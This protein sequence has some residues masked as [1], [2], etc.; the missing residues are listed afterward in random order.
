MV[1]MLNLRRR[2]GDIKERLREGAGLSCGGGASVSCQQLSFS[3]PNRL[4]ESDSSPFWKLASIFLPEETQQ[5]DF[6]VT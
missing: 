5:S 3:L 4:K 1:L 2:S 6:L